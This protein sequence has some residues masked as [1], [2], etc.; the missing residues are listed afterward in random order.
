MIHSHH[1]DGRKS[2]CLIQNEVVDRIPREKSVKIKFLNKEKIKDKV[3]E[4]QDL[5]QIS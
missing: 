2:A 3:R 1:M 5:N 4:D